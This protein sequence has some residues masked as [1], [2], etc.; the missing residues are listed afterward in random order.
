[1]TA[2]A[3]I[4][5]ASGA[6][7]NAVLHGLHGEDGLQHSCGAH[8]VAVDAFEAEERHVGKAGTVY[9]YALH[10]VV[11]ERGGAVDAYEC[12]LVF[13]YIQCLQA[14]IGALAGA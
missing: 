7:N 6:E 13:V 11:V 1:M 3:K 12:E 8:G 14:A 5:K 10:L 2:Y 4:F 9:G